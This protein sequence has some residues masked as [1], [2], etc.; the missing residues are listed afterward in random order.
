[1][2]RGR[3]RVVALVE[4]QDTAGLRLLGR[5]WRGQRHREA[6]V[7][8]RQPERRRRHRKCAPI[9]GTAAPLSRNAAA[10]RCTA[11]ASCFARC[12]A[13]SARLMVAW[14]AH[15]AREQVMD[16]FV[17]P[18]GQSGAE[19]R[20]RIRDGRLHR[21]DR[22]PGARQ[23]AGEPRDPAARR[24]RTISCA[25]PRP[26]RSRAR[27]SPSRNR[28]IRACRPWASDLDIR[29]DL[30][31]YRVWRNGELVEEPT[32]IAPCLARRPGQLRD[33]LLVLVRGGADRGRHRGPP[34]RLRLQRA[35]VP[36]QHRLRAGR[37]CSTARWWCR[38][39]RCSRR[40]R[41][42]RCR[43]PRAFRR[44]TARR[45]ISGC[46]ELIGIARHRQAGLWR[47]GA[48]R[49]GRAAGVLGLRRDAAGGDRRR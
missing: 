15:H 13:R 3:G 49:R 20:R 32:D 44:C 21:A 43:S 30:P 7:E 45:C 46:R 38:C 6:G 28:A 26:T 23:R 41:S 37:A 22:R 29:T 10:P 1:M 19:Q 4:M 33:R 24:W 9:G 39:G 47:R 25:S 18:R 2:D 36:H 12:F 31:R 8:R 17:E 42:A 34:H 35:D 48:G 16:G 11:L 14:P 5:R 40:M 27:C